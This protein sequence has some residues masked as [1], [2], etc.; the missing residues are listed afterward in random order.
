LAEII[1]HITYM[2]RKGNEIKWNLEAMKSFEYKKMAF[3]KSP[4]LASPDFTK[5]FILFSFSSEHT[6]VNVLL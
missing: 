6:I 3:T 2:L 1:K 4:V 5:Y